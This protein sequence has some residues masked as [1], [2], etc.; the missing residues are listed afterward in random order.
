MDTLERISEINVT[1]TRL[2]RHMRFAS[3]RTR[4]MYDEGWRM[5]AQRRIGSRRRRSCS[6]RRK[7]TKPLIFLGAE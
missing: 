5:V 2:L 1:R 4:F 7:H 6:A 3:A